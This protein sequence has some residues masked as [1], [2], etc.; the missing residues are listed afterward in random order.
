[1][2]DVSAA[3]KMFSDSLLF[4][5]RGLSGPAIL[6]LSNYWDVGAQISIN[7]LPEVDLY[8]VLLDKKSTAPKTLVSAVLH[9]YLPRSLSLALCSE[10]LPNA[11]GVERAVQ[12]CRNEELSHF[13]RHLHNWLI[14]PSG[15]EGYRTAEVTRAGV[16]VDQISSKTMQVKGVPGLFFIGEVLDVTGHLG[17]YNF[18]WAW[19]SGFVAG[20]NV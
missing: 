10:F 19:S 18:Q 17:G 13:S 8:Q 2:V 5:H 16:S 20:Q 1:M 4:T 3:G 9:N 11:A 15:T 6:Q 7:L 12:D 14:K